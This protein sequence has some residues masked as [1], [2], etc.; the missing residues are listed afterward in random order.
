MFGQGPRNCIGMRYA[1]LALKVAVVFMLRKYR[2]VPCSKTTKEIEVIFLL[3]C[4][5]LWRKIFYKKLYKPVLKD[6]RACF[7]VI[8][9]FAGKILLL[10]YICL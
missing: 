3:K 4:I 6:I 10:L 8:F 5:S 9:D 7:F 2:L 1:L